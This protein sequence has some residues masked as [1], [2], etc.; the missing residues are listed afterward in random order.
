MESPKGNGTSLAGNSDL[1]AYEGKIKEKLFELQMKR[2]TLSEIR[3]RLNEGLIEKYNLERTLEDIKRDSEETKIQ[4]DVAVQ[5]ARRGESDRANNREAFARQSVQL[6][7]VIKDRNILQ[8]QIRKMQV[9][10]GNLKR[11][12]EEYEEKFRYHVHL[13][14]TYQTKENQ[15]RSYLDTLQTEI[16][17]LEEAQRRLKEMTCSALCISK[18]LIFHVA[19]QKTVIAETINEKNKLETD[20]VSLTAELERIKLQNFIKDGTDSKHSGNILHLEQ[21]KSRQQEMESRLKQS[22]KEILQLEESL[23]K[24]LISTTQLQKTINAKDEKI[25]LLEEK[26]EKIFCDKSLDSVEK[27]PR[28]EESQQLNDDRVDSSAH[29]QQ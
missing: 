1:T 3:S 4:L 29:T 20:I 8:E 23:S 15:W 11:E 26:A 25:K 10:N 28:I 22:E 24:A 13:K 2:G 19:H 21:W 17:S 5:A 9:E 12:V 27:P 6:E 7:A 14:E 16:K 18:K